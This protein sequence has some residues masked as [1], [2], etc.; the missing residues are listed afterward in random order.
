MSLKYYLHTTI[1]SFKLY[2]EN[3]N[4]EIPDIYHDLY[5]SASSEGVAYK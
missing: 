5:I 4:A 3:L 1:K 2:E